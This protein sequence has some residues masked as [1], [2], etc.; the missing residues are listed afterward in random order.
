MKS[1]L[2]KKVIIIFSVMAVL[3]LTA[4]GV[5][6]ATG[7][8]SLPRLSD[9]DGIFY[10][11]TDAEGNVIYSITNQ[12][13]Y[14]EI[15]S[16]DGLDQLLY[17]IDG[18]LLQDY[19]AAITDAEIADKLQ[20]LTYGTDD[21]DAIAALEEDVRETNETTFAQSMILAGYTGHEEDYARIVLAREAYARFMID[22]E[23]D[24][25]DLKVAALHVSSYY[26][27]IKAIKIRF[28]SSA[29]ATATLRHFHLVAFS[30]TSLRE[31]LG[32]VFKTETEVWDHD[33]NSTTAE[34]VADAY[35]TVTPYYFDADGDI[36]NLDDEVEYSNEGDGIYADANDD[37]F[38]LL[39]N[40]DLVDSDSEVVIAAALLFD[41]AEEAQTY[42][43]ENSDY[44]TMSKVDAFDETEEAEVRNEAGDLVYTV[45]F[46]GKIYD[47]T[48]TDVTDTA[49]IVINKTYKAIESMGTV[50][51]NNSR[52][53]TDAE[54]LTFFIDIY[55]YVYGG[56][57]DA[58]DLL[59]PAAD[60]ADLI[61]SDNPYLTHVFD[62][63]KAVQSSLAT[64]MF[65][66]LD[67]SG[68][69]KVPYTPTAK[70]FAG[71]NDT[72][73]YL[74]YKLT[75]PA[76]INAYER[77]LDLIEDNIKLPAQ[78]VDDLELPSTGWYSAKITWTSGNKD[79]IANDG[80]VTLP[81]DVDK[82]VVL[83]YKITANGV[84]R[85]GTITVKVLVSGTTSEVDSTDPGD[86]PTFRELLDDPT[87][88]ESLYRQLLDDAMTNTDTASDTITAKLVAM[89]TAAGFKI[90]DSWVTI[91]YQAVDTAF[92]GVKKGSKT[93]VATLDSRPTYESDAIVETG[94]EITADDLFE[95]ALTK[96]TALYVLYA[97][98]YKEL[99]YS[100]FF[101]EAFGTQRNLDRNKSD[102]M[103]E[104]FASVK[105]SKDYYAYLQQLYASY[106]IDFTYASFS[107]Y[108]YQQYGT[109]TE[110]ELL[111]YFV[112]GELQPY[113]IA[114][115]IENYDLVELLYP[116]VLE[117]YQNFFSLDVSHLIIL[118]DFDEDGTPDD[119]YAYIDALDETG[120][121]EYET[122][123]AG[124]EAAIT[125]YLDDED[126]D[127]ASLVTAYRA[128]AYDDE[129][130]GTFK[131]FGFRIMTEDLN[132]VD[133]EDDTVTHSLTY[134][135][136][137]G[138]YETYVPE[139]VDALVALYQEYRLDQNKDLSEM[140][141]SLVTT[142]YGQHLILVQKGDDF[143]GFS[144]AFT[145]ADPANPV[146]SAG[147]ES[148][149]GEPT[150]EQIKLYAL[151]YFYNI[152]Y[153]LT[154]ADVEETYGIVV[155]N[156]PASVKTALEFY[157]DDLCAN[158]YVVGTL[159]ITMADRL[160][161]GTT[162]NNGYGITDAAFQASLSEI[163]DVYY[164]ALF[165][166]YL[167]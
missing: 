29:E 120:V 39:E 151:Y 96:N 66:T 126:H 81:T 130:W 36:L 159:N 117:F 100:P 167:D 138:V 37:E 85:T 72:D 115:T 132:V 107:E 8:S 42:K 94:L 41:S 108:A 23:G 53:L 106:G 125:E 48:H 102:R 10:E 13:L 17:L 147:S 32:Y 18:Y 16:N 101:E 122:K 1:L 104:M 61:A 38:T 3:V 137:Y 99:L 51:V 83:T 63:V 79:F 68:E 113:L 118:L 144:A 56:I 52:E 141:S 54:V 97:S 92:T 157:F 30:A 148:A 131:Q 55:N 5:S 145:E 47:L 89:R 124:F 19:V 60:A 20:L 45:S 46:D 69:D 139:Y 128:A 7:N 162:A 111:Q 15:K 87:L 119:Y 133:S 121:D 164:Q 75:Q 156:L 25:T 78:T 28:M 77:M 4:I 158:L 14:D 9:P 134:S 71:S 135:G 11:R 80:T 95:Y 98:Q 27:D 142:V 59:D 6:F 93:L 43:D 88:Y 105:N 155:P 65:K 73:Y 136:E 57:R 21:D 127:F 58:A 103:Q 44:Y 22:T 165:G 31:Y 163:Q 74:I 160:E 154:D 123:L 149:D 62:D 140:M 112:Q 33:G 49:D 34:V 109:K 116:T 67:I 84:S 161:V 114:E 50:T 86:A 150:L 70:S 129:T 40:G 143:N 90:Y 26:E 146:Y 35:T 2:M 64:Y 152:V 110:L 76:K 12:D 166:Q 91:D 153:D 82:D 24:I